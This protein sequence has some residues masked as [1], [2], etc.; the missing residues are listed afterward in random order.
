MDQVSQCSVCHGSGLKY[1][2][3]NCVPSNGTPETTTTGCPTCEGTGKRKPAPFVD[4]QVFQHTGGQLLGVFRMHD[5][6]PNKASLYST[7]MPIEE[8][9]RNA[10]YVARSKSVELVINDPHG[11]LSTRVSS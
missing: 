5:P 7:A 6:R 9:L 2:P 1:L 8:A 10:R 3:F 11:R 4:L